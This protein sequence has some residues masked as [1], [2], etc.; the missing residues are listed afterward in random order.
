MLIVVKERTKE[1]GIRRAL[2]AYTGNIRSQIIKL[3]DAPDFTMNEETT[4]L[5][6]FT[7]DSEGEIIVLNVDS[8]DHDILKYVRKN[9]NYQKIENPGKRDKLYSMPLKMQA[10]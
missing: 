3:M 8:R 4:V 1:I 10:I 7:F 9:L 6:T 2:G 5:I